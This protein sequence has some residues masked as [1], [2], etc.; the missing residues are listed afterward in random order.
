[1]EK[2][3][4]VKRA[5]LLIMVS[6]FL[7]FFPNESEAVE[8]TVKVIVTMADVHEGPD[9]NTPRLTVVLL[10]WILETEGKE[11]SWYKVR[12]PLNASNPP[13]T[14]YIHE[15]NI[16]EVTT[17]DTVER[18]VKIIVASASVL[19]IPEEGSPVLKTIPRDW[20]LFSSAK[21]GDWYLVIVP[22]DASGVSSKGYIYKDNVEVVKEMQEEISDEVDLGTRQVTSP[23]PRTEEPNFT[24]EIQGLLGISFLDFEK[25][26]IGDPLN[27]NKMLFQPCVQAFFIRTGKL[28][29]GAEGGYSH[30]F[31]YEYIVGER[32]KWDSYRALLLAR[33]N[34]DRKWFVTFGSGYLFDQEEY[35]IMGEFGYKLPLSRNINIPIKV[36][37]DLIFHSPILVPLGISLGISFGY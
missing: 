3:N 30:Y 1:M 4:P 21:E 23:P 37:G 12:A 28:Q 2:T 15:S 7:M 5:A 17:S 20:T 18:H 11:G 31:W 22:P 14:G 36:R 13:V 8:V 16:E 26:G 19:A 9:E 34:I 27:Y 6:L 24:F 29:I 32:Q 33:V 10:G 25:W 35:E